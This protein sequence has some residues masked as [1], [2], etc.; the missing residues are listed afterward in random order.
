MQMQSTYPPRNR[1]WRRGCGFAFGLLLWFG[2]AHASG[3]PL[4]GAWGEVSPGDTP[5]SVLEA[6]RADHL[7][8]FDP[9]ILQQ[10]P[11]S[12]LGTWVVIAAQPPWDNEERVLT[13]YPPRPGAIQV[14]TGDQRHV[15]AMDDFSA[16]VHGY[17]RL[18]WRIPS[19]LPA[20]APILL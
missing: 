5:Q 17:G 16:P 11:R 9:S 8:S 19:T 6:Y 1:L 13:I 4:N 15:L 3:M 7:K 18:A 10:F 2:L 14:I 12:Q 20:S